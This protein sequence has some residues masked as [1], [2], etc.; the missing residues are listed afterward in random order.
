VT[1]VAKD[2]TESK[3]GP[4]G[5]GSPASSARVSASTSTGRAQRLVILVVFADTGAPITREI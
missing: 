2:P 1:T 4:G 5:V 3:H